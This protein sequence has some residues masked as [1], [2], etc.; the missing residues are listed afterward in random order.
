MSEVGQSDTTA[1]SVLS[2]EAVVDPQ[3]PSKMP[4]VA[5]PSAICTLFVTFMCFDMPIVNLTQVN[6]RLNQEYRNAKF[7]PIINFTTMNISF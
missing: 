4:A 5:N 3:A 6:S 2:V 7:K 1:A